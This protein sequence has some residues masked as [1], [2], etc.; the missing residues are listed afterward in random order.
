MTISKGDIDMTILGNIA[1]GNL[2]WNITVTL[3]GKHHE[4]LDG[5]LFADFRYN[6]D[7]VKTICVNKGYDVRKIEMGIF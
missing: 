4:G 5:M 1:K 3:H 7:T 2:C 6:K